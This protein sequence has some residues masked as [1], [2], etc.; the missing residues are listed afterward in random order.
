MISTLLDFL[1]IKNKVILHDAQ[2]DQRGLAVD[3]IGRKI[4]YL[5][6]SALYVCELNGHYK[7]VLLNSSYLQEPTSIVVDPFAGYVFFTDWAYPPFIGRI[8]LDGKNF[9]KIV[10]Q[11]IGNPIGLAIDIVTK[12]IWWTDTHLKRIEFSNYNGRNR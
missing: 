5:S 9:T 3:W 10:T 7:T 1:S 2:K 11:D 8:G 4:Y 12:R 6:R